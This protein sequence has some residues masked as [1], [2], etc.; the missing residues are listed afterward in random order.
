[1]EWYRRKARNGEQ[2]RSL[3]PEDVQA[4]YKQAFKN[5]SHEL[6][7]KIDSEFKSTNSRLNDSKEFS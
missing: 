3:T 5:L 1:M 4:N 2:Q 7:K 6:K